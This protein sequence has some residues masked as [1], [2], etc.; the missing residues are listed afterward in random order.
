MKDKIRFSDL[1]TPLKIGIISIY[2][3]LTLYLISLI[4]GL[5]IGIQGV[6]K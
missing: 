5:I 6:L 4:I 1:S 2:G 3:I